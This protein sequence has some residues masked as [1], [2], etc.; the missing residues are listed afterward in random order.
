[1]GIVAL[2]VGISILIQSNALYEK[3]IKYGGSGNS[4]ID[5]SSGACTATFS[6]TK[7]ID[8]DLYLYYELT[9]YYQN[10]IK[11]V[12]SIPWEQ[13]TGDITQTES[14]L[15]P[16]CTE[17]ATMDGTNLLNPCGLVAKSFFTDTYS[18]DTS[19]SK[20]N[21]ATPSTVTLDESNL[22]WTSDELFVQP[23]G[24]KF[25]KVDSCA[26]GCQASG[27]EAGCG[28]YM[29]PST[30]NIY[31]YS[32]PNTNTTTYLYEMYPDQISPIEGVTD[33]HFKVWM[34]VAALPD[35]R[36][37][38]ASIPGPFKNGDT[39]AIDIV[40][41]YDTNWDGTKSL[42][43]T[44]KYSL[45]LPNSGVG[46]TYIVSSCF[47]LAVAIS[48]LVKE[49]LFPRALGSPTALNWKT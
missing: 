43:L 12:S 11:Y 15:E 25:E 3:A 4:D 42:V 40:S 31:L 26:I 29:D 22:V 6:I 35:F 8:N 39:V 48:F 2:P 41:V 10:N 28:C 5:C 45:G 49:K 47:C 9:N 17:A 34:N 21:G 24:F 20:V 1:M 44:E 46:I 16:I 38:Y 14:D 27:M 37:P 19:A 30:S 36:K 13:L 33:E 18:M 7:D 23:D 32:Y